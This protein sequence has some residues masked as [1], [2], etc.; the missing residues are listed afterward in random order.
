MSKSKQKAVK[1][2][3]L[4]PPPLS[5]LAPR[6]SLG[7]P[8]WLAGN[9]CSGNKICS[10]LSHM[11]ITKTSLSCSLWSRHWDARSAVPATV[12]SVA[13]APLD[14][15]AKIVRLQFFL[16]ATHSGFSIAVL[17]YGSRKNQL[18]HSRPLQSQL[19]VHCVAGHGDYLI[20]KL[21]GRQGKQ[22]GG[23]AA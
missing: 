14:T 23:L 7:L 6:L 22:G 5:S 3:C 13:S 17:R 12:V 11:A 20:M 19:K 4:T 15:W 18:A 16:V 21:H 9:L 1:A 10:L 2:S 8:V